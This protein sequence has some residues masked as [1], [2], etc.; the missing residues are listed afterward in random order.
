M[1][2]LWGVDA[3][4]SH[5][6]AMPQEDR[7]SV[8]DKNGKSLQGM[9][10]CGQTHRQGPG[11]NTKFQ[12]HGFQLCLIIQNRAWKK[13]I[14]IKYLRIVY[15]YLLLTVFLLTSF[16]LDIINHYKVLNNE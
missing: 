5:P 16:V 13:P 1:P 9:D 10:R 7:V 12:S 3:E 11:Y 15:F 8:K 14:E 4:V 2:D 6:G